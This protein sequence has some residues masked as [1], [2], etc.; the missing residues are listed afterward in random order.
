MSNEDKLRRALEPFAN[1][2]KNWSPTNG[3]SKDDPM[4]D[5]CRI[6]GNTELTVADLRL[7]REALAATQEQRGEPGREQIARVMYE[8]VKQDRY[9]GEGKAWED[10]SQDTRD[11]WLRVA[12]AVL[13]V[14]SS[15]RDAL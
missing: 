13:A 2:A 4:L 15:K 9:H 1:E 3:W 14:S 6:S 8:Q 5:T 7:A 10:R 12:D 11:Q